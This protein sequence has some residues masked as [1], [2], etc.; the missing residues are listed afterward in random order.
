MKISICIPS[1]N[2]EK[3]IGET[4]DSIINQTSRPYEIIVNDNASTDKTRDIVSKYPM[5]TY[6]ENT[7]NVGGPENHNIC[8]DRASGEYI[9]LLSS[10]DYF[11][12]SRVIEQLKSVINDNVPDCIALG[13]G[14]GDGN[15]LTYKEYSGREAIYLM[16]FGKLPFRQIPS[17]MVFKKSILNGLRLKSDNE[18]GYGDD[19]QF[20][21]EIMKKSKTY[22][23]IE[24]PMVIYRTHQ[25]SATN[26]IDIDDRFQ[27]HG[28]ILKKWVYT[29][30]A[31]I[32]GWYG[33]YWVMA[34]EYLRVRNEMPDGQGKTRLLKNGFTIVE[35]IIAHL[36]NFGIIYIPQKLKI[37]VKDIVFNRLKKSII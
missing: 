37:T 23:N 34:G 13:V 29:D 10:D 32:L 25:A 11:P 4:L 9:I 12:H 21:L 33:G 6:S 1:Y 17:M 2:S 7:N 14:Q 36:R 8:I 15:I 28:Q 27:M 26:S 19:T 24:T 22:I 18:S 31:D 35:K 16:F 20:Y 30:Y 5:V 3:Y